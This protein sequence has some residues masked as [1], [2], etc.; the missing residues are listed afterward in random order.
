MPEP[1][2]GRGKA[3]PGDAQDARWEEEQQGHA[4]SIPTG[5]R[6]R[7]HGQRRGATTYLEVLR[8]ATAGVSGCQSLRIAMQRAR[9][10]HEDVRPALRLSAAKKDAG[11]DAGHAAY[12]AAR[13]AITVPCPLNASGKPR[14]GPCSSQTLVLESLR[15]TFIDMG[16]N[17]PSATVMAEVAK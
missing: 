4:E 13:R 5:H 17:R 6:S 8:S 7:R 15:N 12:S 9:W 3:G 16:T 2:A 11:K 14:N 10:S 1:G